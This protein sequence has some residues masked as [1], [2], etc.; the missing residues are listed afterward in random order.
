MYGQLVED[1]YRLT[2]AR[3]KA[4][5]QVPALAERRCQARLLIHTE[6][7]LSLQHVQ[8]SGSD[9]YLQV[10]SEERWQQGGGEEIVHT[11]TRTR[12]SGYHFTLDI[13]HAHTAE[14][15]YVNVLL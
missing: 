6:Y 4:S 10:I 2:D 11:P 12:Q 14:V 3:R 1:F 13:V 15:G 7:L 5:G 9:G 8:V